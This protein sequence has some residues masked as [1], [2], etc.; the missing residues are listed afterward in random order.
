MMRRRRGGR[1][2]IEEIIVGCFVLDVRLLY[3]MYGVQALSRCL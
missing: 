3:S 2:R 1:R